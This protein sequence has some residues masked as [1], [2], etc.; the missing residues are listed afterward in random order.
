MYNHLAY[1]IIPAY[2][3]PGLHVQGQVVKLWAAIRDLRYNSWEASQSI[4]LEIKSAPEVVL[5]ELYVISSEFDSSLP[6]PI[7]D[8]AARNSINSIDANTKIQAFWAS[9]DN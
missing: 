7:H 2:Q 1:L 3:V 9:P 5:A 4:Y 8:A 6:V